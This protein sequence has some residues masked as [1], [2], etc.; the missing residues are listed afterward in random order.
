[1]TKQSIEHIQRE[2]KQLFPLGFLLIG[3]VDYDQDGPPKHASLAYRLNEN[4]SLLAAG[5]QGKGWDLAEGFV[6]A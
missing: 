4:P 5:V 6:D 3:V 2:L 1:M